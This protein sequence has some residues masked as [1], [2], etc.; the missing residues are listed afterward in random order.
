MAAVHAVVVVVV[1]AV[2]GTVVIM[3]AV[4]WWSRVVVR[5]RP[6]VAIVVSDRRLA[7]GAYQQR[8]ARAATGRRVGGRNCRARLGEVMRE[9]NGRGGL[10]Q[11]D[12]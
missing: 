1:G 8:S 4:L 2:A 7:V 9:G 10:R 5:V 3:R 12:F 11:R 6:V